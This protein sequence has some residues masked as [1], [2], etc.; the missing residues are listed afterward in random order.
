MEIKLS[1]SN[2]KGKKWKVI[3]D[4][5]IVHFG[6]K[7]YSDFTK[8]KDPK[9]KDRYIN[10][11]KKNEDWTKKGIKTAGFWSRWLTWN[12][13]TIKDSIKHIEDNFNVNVRLQKGFGNVEN[14]F[15][16]Q[17]KIQK[18]IYKKLN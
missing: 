6:A 9:R 10:R 5:S 12:K 14:K 15:E 16:I 18:N 1:K 17:N 3:V 4:G 13:P 7:G 2:R 8:H 11:H